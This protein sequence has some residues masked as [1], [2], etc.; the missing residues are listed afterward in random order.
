MSKRLVLGGG[1]CLKDWYWEGAVSKR[2]V[3]EG[4]SV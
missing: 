1:Q 2:L 4:G 3:L